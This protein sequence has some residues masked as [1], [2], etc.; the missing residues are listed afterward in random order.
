MKTWQLSW[1]HTTR[2]GN[3]KDHRAHY[4]T[5]QAAYR[6]MEW[7]QEHSSATNFKIEESEI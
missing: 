3:K 6:Q 4:R 7:M 5:K 1:T 2:T